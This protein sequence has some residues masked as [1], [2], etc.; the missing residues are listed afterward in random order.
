MLGSRREIE[1]GFHFGSSSNRVEIRE[2][3]RGGNSGGIKNELTV[4]RWMDGEKK[5]C[6]AYKWLRLLQSFT[7]IR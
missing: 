2:G 5:R 1:T 6:I 7:H 3:R 4:D